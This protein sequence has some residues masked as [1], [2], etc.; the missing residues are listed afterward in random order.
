M[1]QA[2]TSMV[3]T[4]LDHPRWFSDGGQGAT[5]KRK[6]A[7]VAGAQSQDDPTTPNTDDGQSAGDQRKRRNGKSRKDRKAKRKAAK[8]TAVAMADN[9]AESA[10]KYPCS[11][12]SG[13]ADTPQRLMPK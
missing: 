3:R 6:E 2:L 4:T 5:T 11:H 8:A 12:P 9:V 1:S 7:T 13:S 10:G